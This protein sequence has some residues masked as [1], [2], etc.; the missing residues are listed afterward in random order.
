MHL[1]RSARA[2]PTQPAP[3]TASPGTS[4]TG[5]SLLTFL[6]YYILQEQ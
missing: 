4:T 2:A 1:V 5:M 3:S 6:A